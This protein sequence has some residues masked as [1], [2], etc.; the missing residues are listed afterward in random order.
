[1]RVPE[2]VV[3]LLPQVVDA[4][5]LTSEEVRQ[6]L[7]ALVVIDHAIPLDV[8]RC[9]EGFDRSRRHRLFPAV[10]KRPDGDHTEHHRGA[11]NDRD[12]L[13]RRQP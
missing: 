9:A 2:A 6:I 5:A 11:P 13:D 1:M 12:R 7:P 4:L 10:V 3:D 8:R